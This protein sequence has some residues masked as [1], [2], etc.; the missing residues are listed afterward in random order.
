MRNIELILNLLRC[1]FDEKYWMAL[2]RQVLVEVIYQ[3]YWNLW[4]RKKQIKA[5][6]LSIN[7]AFY[8]VWSSIQW[9][10]DEAPDC[11]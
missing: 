4:Y 3:R 7:Q 9:G 1:R 11:V 5:K 10:G 2:L 6:I 8:D